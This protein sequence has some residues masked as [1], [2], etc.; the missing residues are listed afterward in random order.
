MTRVFIYEEVEQFFDQDTYGD[1]LELLV[2]LIN[3]DY[4]IEHLRM[5]V[6][7]YIE[8]FGDIDYE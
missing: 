3:R 4:S 5:D 7:E 6:E 8:K 2:A 1:L